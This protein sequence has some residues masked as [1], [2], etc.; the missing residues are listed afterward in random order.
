MKLNGLNISGITRI[1]IK[2]DKKPT[3]Y[4]VLQNGVWYGSKIDSPWNITSERSHIKQIE[5]I[6]YA[7]A[8]P[9][10]Y[11]VWICKD[12]VNIRILPQLEKKQST[13]FLRWSAL[14]DDE[15]TRKYTAI[16]FTN[17]SKMNNWLFEDED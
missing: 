11:Y 7:V 8:H 13:I 14:E 6:K 4:W 2:S 1:V 3:K 12:T 15:R 9:D 16:P 17:K 5:F 10:K